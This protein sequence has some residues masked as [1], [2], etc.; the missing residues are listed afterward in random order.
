MTRIP[1]WGR[2]WIWRLLTIVFFMVSLYALWELHKCGQGIEELEEGSVNQEV[3]LYAE[4][5]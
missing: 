1:G 4:S 3:I 2:I 5:L